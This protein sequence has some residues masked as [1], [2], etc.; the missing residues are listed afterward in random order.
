MPW[1]CFCFSFFSSRIRHTKY[2][3]DWISDVWLFRSGVELRRSGAQFTGLCPLHGPEK[4]PSFFVHPERGFFCHGCGAHGDALDFIRLVDGVSLEEAIATL[5]GTGSSAP[6]RA[7]RATAP[8]TAPVRDAAGLFS[9]LAV[10][11]DAGEEYL[12]RRGLLYRDPEV[13]R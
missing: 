10:H 8:S 9:R 12:T 7:P 5:A 2:W 4:T 13:M 1:W 11:D 3:R 6:R